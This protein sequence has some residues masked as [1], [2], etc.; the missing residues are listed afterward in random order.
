MLL[1]V[2]HAQVSNAQVGK[3][4][5]LAAG[6]PADTTSSSNG[7]GNGS[8]SS[9]PELVMDDFRHSAEAAYA[10][11]DVP[12]SVIDILSELRCYLQ[13]RGCCR[14]WPCSVVGV[15][16]IGSGLLLQHAARNLHAAAWIYMVCASG[17]PHVFS[18]C[19]S[20]TFDPPCRYS[21]LSFGLS[22][23]CGVM[24]CE[25]GCVERAV[26]VTC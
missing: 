3:L 15:G 20:T 24:W 18:T 16:W 4:A 8:G 9:G 17:R 10:A 11:V 1:C 6:R 21:L 19:S 14:E 22:A 13:V 23:C 2:W 12:D 25:Q 26:P 7:N 5:R